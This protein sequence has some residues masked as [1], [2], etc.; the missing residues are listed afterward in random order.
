MGRLRAFYCDQA[1][2]TNEVPSNAVMI[3]LAKIPN[4]QV[5]APQ[6]LNRFAAIP[7][8]LLDDNAGICASGVIKSSLG[9]RF[10][11]RDKRERLLG[12]CDNSDSWPIVD[13]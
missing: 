9:H 10:F 6:S 11:S 12:I 13:R 3:C 5:T 8:V 4:P 1:V 7:L 2:A